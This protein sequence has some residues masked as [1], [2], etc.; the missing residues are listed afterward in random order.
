M[1]KSTQLRLLSDTSSGR[2]WL[3]IP[4]LSEDACTIFR[5]AYS[6]GSWEV[7]SVHSMKSIL[8]WLHCFMQATGR[9]L[10]RKLGMARSKKIV[11]L[12]RYTYSNIA[13]QCAKIDDQ[14]AQDKLMKWILKLEFDHFAIPQPDLTC[15]LMSVL[16]Y[17]KETQVGPV[18]QW[19]ELP[20]RN[21]GYPR[22]EP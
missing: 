21:K 19:Q 18:R 22:R 11:L 8:I 10:R 17:R 1:G 5:W 2:L 6:R 9:M 7:S 12:D 4:S 20:E 13:Y 3:W 16:F 14:K 15:S